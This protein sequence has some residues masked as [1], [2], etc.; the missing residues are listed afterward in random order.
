MKQRLAAGA[1]IGPTTSGLVHI[2]SPVVLGMADSEKT[3]IATT[4]IRA[5]NIR[6]IGF[7]VNLLAPQYWGPSGSDVILRIEP[8]E[9]AGP[10]PWF[11]PVAAE[12]KSE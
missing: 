3:V 4:P 12:G 11:P 1:V 10:A 6:T 5:Y 2:Y 7:H 8:A 9:D